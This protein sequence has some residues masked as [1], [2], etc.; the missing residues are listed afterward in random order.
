[1]RV[2]L[3][4]QARD[5]PFSFTGRSYNNQVIEFSAEWIAPQPHRPQSTVGGTAKCTGVGRLPIPNLSAKRGAV[6]TG[7]V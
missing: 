4:K 1:M 5:G 7:A 3:R 2:V 6:L